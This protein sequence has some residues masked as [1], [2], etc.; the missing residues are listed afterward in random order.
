MGIHDYSC[1][2]CSS[3][4]GDQCLE[5]W[6]DYYE[7]NDEVDYED[8]QCSYPPPDGDSQKSGSGKA[9]LY[10]FK[11]NPLIKRCNP[12]KHK[13][14]NYSWDA[15]DFEK[16]NGYYGYSNV[17]NR[18]R[19]IY[20]V[21]K[22]ED[23]WILNICPCC[24]QY[25]ISDKLDDPPQQLL[26]QILDK[27]RLY[28]FSQFQDRKLDLVIND[29]EDFNLE[30]FFPLSCVRIRDYIRAFC[31]YLNL[32]EDNIDFEF[33]TLSTNKLVQILE[34]GKPDNK[35][36]DPNKLGSTSD[37]EIISPLEMAFGNENS[38]QLESLITRGA[39]VTD[40]Q[41]YLLLEDKDYRHIVWDNL[42]LFDRS[43][44]S[45][46]TLNDKKIWKYAPKSFFKL[47][48]FKRAIEQLANLDN[49]ELVEYL[50]K[51]F[52]KKYA[53]VKYYDYVCDKNIALMIKLFDLGF[54]PQTHFDHVVNLSWVEGVKLCLKYGAKLDKAS[55]YHLD[56]HNRPEIKKLFK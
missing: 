52:P 41:I 38:E 39:K 12:I 15:W 30:T 2:L 21:W 43:T 11:K 35:K 26:V 48:D 55:K 19:P 34:K 5:S 44:I 29:T 14:V 17:L 50:I 45:R 54:S 25:F 47:E 23:K 3:I 33:E 4:E 27:F 28:P 49:A 31:S 8:K 32:R 40:D 56:R 22:H 42:D 37:G 16:G 24:Y 1:F 13:K 36:Y 7:S 9:Y 18:D 20:S 6:T 51:I 53:N 10:F 46:L